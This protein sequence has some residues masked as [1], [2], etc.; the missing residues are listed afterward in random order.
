MH[1]LLSEWTVLAAS[2]AMVL[3]LAE[4]MFGVTGAVFFLRARS[5]DR[6]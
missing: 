2:L 6:E 3:L 1:A 5:D 4:N